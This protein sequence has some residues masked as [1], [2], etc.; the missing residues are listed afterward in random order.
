MIESADWILPE[1]KPNY[2]DLKIMKSAAGY[3]IGTEYR[4]THVSSPEPGSRD[5]EYF[6]TSELAE[7]AFSEKSWTQRWSP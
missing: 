3:Y 7:K 6:A 5:S 4:Y 1:D 2:S